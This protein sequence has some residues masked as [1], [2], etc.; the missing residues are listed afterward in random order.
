MP[1]SHAHLFFSSVPRTTFSVCWY[2]SFMTSPE[3][4]L[5][6]SSPW[7]W[8]LQAGIPSQEQRGC[9]CAPCSCTTKPCWGQ[10]CALAVLPV[11]WIL[12]TAQHWPKPR[13]KLW[14]SQL[15]AP[16]PPPDSAHILSEAHI[17]KQASVAGAGVCEPNFESSTKSHKSYLVLG[18][19]SIKCFQVSRVK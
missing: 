7:V 8:C 1:C 19:S 4:H 3:S 16:K 10:G 17:C 6:P 5:V 14:Q 2:R 15:M 18:G 9:G 13:D 12:F 11:L